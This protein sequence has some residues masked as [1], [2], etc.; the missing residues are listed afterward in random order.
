[1]HLL[2]QVKS[3]TPP[4]FTMK[5]VFSLTIYTYE[6]FLIKIESKENII[7]QAMKIK[8]FSKKDAK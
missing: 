5:T 1:M 8:L 3:V 2:L 7:H 6:M 4:I